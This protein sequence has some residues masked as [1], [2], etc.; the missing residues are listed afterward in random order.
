MEMSFAPKELYPPVLESIRRNRGLSLDRLRARVTDT[1][2]WF[3]LELSGDSAAID[4]FLR[5]HG[6]RFVRS[7]AVA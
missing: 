2:A 1:E 3:E 7:L 5:R 6:A 4:D